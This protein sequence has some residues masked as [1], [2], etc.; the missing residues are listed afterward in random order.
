MVKLMAPS[1]K[2]RVMNGIV[3]GIWLV[4]ERL[5]PLAFPKRDDLHY[6]RIETEGDSHDSWLLVEQERAAL[7][8]NPMDELADA[9][10]ELYVEKPRR[11]G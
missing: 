7:I 1:E 3:P 2:E 9:R 10:F 8:L 4:Y 5:A 11:H 6:F